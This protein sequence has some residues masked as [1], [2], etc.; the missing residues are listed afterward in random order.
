MCLITSDDGRKASYSRVEEEA[1]A[2][3]SRSL[4]DGQKPRELN[5]GNG[6]IV[7]A[8]FRRRGSGGDPRAGLAEAA[9]NGAGAV[10]W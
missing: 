7:F 2:R 3:R 5:N 10:F 1:R 9:P 8:S 4:A 6:F